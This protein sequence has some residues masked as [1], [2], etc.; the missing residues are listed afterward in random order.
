MRMEANSP[1]RFPVFWGFR[2][3]ECLADAVQALP[4]QVVFL[5]ITDLGECA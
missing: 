2:K 4:I 3:T 1:V 5:I